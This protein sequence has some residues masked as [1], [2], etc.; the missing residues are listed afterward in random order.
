[1][2]KFS[3]VFYRPSDRLMPDFEAGYTAFLAMVEQIP[4]ITRR[5]VV[6]V[7]GSPEGTTRFYRV[8]ELYFE[9]REV[10]SAALNTE[11]G[12]RAGAGLYEVFGPKGYAFAT[13]FADVY[14]EAGGSTPD[15][16]ED[17]GSEQ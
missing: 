15:Q 8:L 7:L 13:Y 1:M 10:M 6:D 11:A 4:N 17:R 16:P 14:E 9:D 2:V 12:Q 5:Q 3:I